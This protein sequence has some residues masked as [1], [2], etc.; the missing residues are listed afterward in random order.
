MFSLWVAE[1]LEVG[2]FHPCIYTSVFACQSEKIGD[3]IWRDRYRDSEDQRSGFFFFFFCECTPGCWVRTQFGWPCGLVK[4]SVWMCPGFGGSWLRLPDM[5]SRKLAFMS[6]ALRLTLWNRQ[7]YLGYNPAPG[8]TLEKVL[9]H[10]HLVSGT[11]DKYWDSEDLRKIHIGTDRDSAKRICQRKKVTSS[12]K[13]WLPVLVEGILPAIYLM[14]VRTQH[15]AI[16]WSVTHTLLLCLH[17]FELLCFCFFLPLWT[18][19]R[20]IHFN[21]NLQY[22]VGENMQM[23]VHEPRMVFPHI[24]KWMKIQHKIAYNI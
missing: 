23:K 6:C 19:L 10:T 11:Y 16:L 21:L 12:P 4:R 18:R 2:N 20:L 8:P 9:C 14:K 5:S 24:Y 1:N 13:S 22:N 15:I 17:I 3:N 7:A